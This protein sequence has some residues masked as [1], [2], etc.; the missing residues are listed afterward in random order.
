MHLVRNSL[1]EAGA[2]KI[3]KVVGCGNDG[4]GDDAV[5]LHVVRRLRRRLPEGVEVIETWSEP[6]ALMDWWE[7]ADAVWVVDA[8][9][10]GAKPGT[11]HRLDASE[12]PL[13]AHLF[14]A[15]THHFGL[16]QTVELA[17]VLGR[18]PARLVVYGI[19][20]ACFD[21]REGLGSE[22]DAAVEIVA[23]AVSREVSRCRAA[24]GDE[25]S[26]GTDGR[27]AGRKPSSGSAPGAGGAPHPVS[28]RLTMC[29]ASASLSASPA[30][31]HALHGFRRRATP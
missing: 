9:V 11:V 14:A 22:L 23:A 21:S 28:D 26:T 27:G 19:E 4:R 15:S 10:S 1:P 24:G 5:G 6:T 18:L 30:L 31:S 20:G 13:P 16:A 17:R 7:G 8:V 12:C 2:Q 3:L 29:S 25:A